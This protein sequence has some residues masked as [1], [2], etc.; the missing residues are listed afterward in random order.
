MQKSEKP[1]L[2]AVLIIIIVCILWLISQ[3]TL[4]ADS[5]Q[6]KIYIPDMVAVQ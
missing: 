1:K 2:Y 6:Y 3:E 5:N 4:H